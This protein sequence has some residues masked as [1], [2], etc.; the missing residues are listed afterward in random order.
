MVGN[1]YDLEFAV[2]PDGSTTEL[3]LGTLVLARTTLAG[4][5]RWGG[6]YIELKASRFMKT[7]P[8]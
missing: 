4:S 5:M 8:Q 1:N 6:R 7:I 2:R 3:K